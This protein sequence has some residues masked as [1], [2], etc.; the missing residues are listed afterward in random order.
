MSRGGRAVLLVIAFACAVFAFGLVNA[1]FG[2]D[3]NPFFNVPA[4][5]L[6]GIGAIVLFLRAV[7]RR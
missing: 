7:A 2:G 3:S 6:L 5:V 4:A 1:L